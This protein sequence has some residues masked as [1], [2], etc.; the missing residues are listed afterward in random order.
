MGD[1]T[2]VS[3]SSGMAD[4]LYA[5]KNRGDTYEDVLRRLVKQAEMTPEE[6]LKRLSTDLGEPITVG[7]RVYED[8]DVHEL[9]AAGAGETA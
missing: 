2:T 3:V 1:R 5:L 6:R 7:E 4:D 8:G 9:A